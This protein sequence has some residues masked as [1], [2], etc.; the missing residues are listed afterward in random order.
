MADGSLKRVY[1]FPLRNPR[2][3]ELYENKKEQDF[4]NANRRKIGLKDII[5]L[6]SFVI[7]SITV[8]TSVRVAT[9]LQETR[10]KA[11]ANQVKINLFPKKLEIETG[12][13]FALIPQAVTAENKKISSLSFSLVFDPSYLILTGINTDVINYFTLTGQTAFDQANSGGK[14]QMQFESNDPGSAPGGTVSL[15]QLQFVSL[16]EGR[17]SVYLEKSEMKVVFTSGDIAEL[18]MDGLSEITSKP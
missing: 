14:L 3:N 4:K 2:L 18:E 16:R 6:F 12:Q 9:Q 10:T 5:V 13:H 1:P 15:P 17:S 11:K 7:A 8:L